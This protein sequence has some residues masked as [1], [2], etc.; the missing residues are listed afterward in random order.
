MTV[1]ESMLFILP[2]IGICVCVLIIAV[3]LIK[4][5][6]EYVECQ[7]NWN[8]YKRKMKRRF[9]SMPLA[10]CY[11]RDCKTWCER[12][13]DDTSGKCDDGFAGKYTGDDFF[14]KYAKPRKTDPDTEGSQ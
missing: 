2:F 13:D 11:C 3:A 9:D 4:E 12:D 6:W 5:L 8:K 1:L 14:C 7:I 10:Q